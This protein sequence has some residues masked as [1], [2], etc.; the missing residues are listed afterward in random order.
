MT[1]RSLRLNRQRL[2]AAAVRSPDRDF[3]RHHEIRRW[4]RLARALREQGIGR[5]ESVRYVESPA[6]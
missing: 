5:I 2:Q 1:A 4:M 3:M 6:L